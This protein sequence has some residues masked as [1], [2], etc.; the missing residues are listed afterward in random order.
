MNKLRIGSFTHFLLGGLAFFTLSATP[1]NAQ[2][3]TAAGAAS[4]TPKIMREFRGIKLGMKTEAVHTALGKPESTVE[5]R[6]EYKMG[7]EDLLTVHYEN[8]AVKAIQLYFA[9]L[10]NAPAWTDVVGDTEIKQTES[11]AKHARRVMSEEKFWV[12]MFQNKDGT[13]TTVT[14]QS[15]GTP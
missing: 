10:K 6:E 14:I 5:N 9:N 12:S 2:R 7:G 8:G 15:T 3:P 13:V 1:A 4:A 11:G